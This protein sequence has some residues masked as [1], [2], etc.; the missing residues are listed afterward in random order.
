MPMGKRGRV[1]HVLI[2]MG[3]QLIVCI[4]L[5]ALPYF[6]TPVGEATIYFTL[7]TNRVYEDTFGP[8]NR[9]LLVAIPLAILWFLVL[10]LCQKAVFRKERVMSQGFRWLAGLYFLTFVI[11]FVVYGLPARP[12]HGTLVPTFVAMAVIL[13]TMLAGFNQ[14]RY[15]LLSKGALA[16]FFSA[17]YVMFPHRWGGGFINLTPEMPWLLL[18]PLGYAIFLEWIGWCVAKGARAGI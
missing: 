5:Y 2:P 6:V 8:A 11:L 18:F 4:L 9:Y 7:S 10:C 14:F 12:V 1:A 16:L 17:T 15:W 3:V 13:S